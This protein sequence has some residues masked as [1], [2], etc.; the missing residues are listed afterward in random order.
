MPGF[1]DAQRSPLAACAVRSLATSCRTKLTFTRDREMRPYGERAMAFNLY[2]R[3]SP[4]NA[5]FCRI[6]DADVAAAEFFDAGRAVGMFSGDRIRHR[7]ICQ[8][9]LGLHGAPAA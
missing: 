3:P 4:R 6:S 7:R 5:I 1:E 2:Q 9:A 8:L